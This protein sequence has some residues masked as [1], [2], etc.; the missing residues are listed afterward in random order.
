MLEDLF[1]P[2]WVCSSIL[3][4]QASAPK[5]GR[6]SHR[7]LDLF[8]CLETCFRWISRDST[9]LLLIGESVETVSLTISCSIFLAVYLGMQKV[10]VLA[11]YKTVKQALVN[12]A[13]EFEEREVTSIFYDFNKGHGILFSNG[14]VWKKIRCF[15]LSTL[16]DFG[17]GKRIT[18][19]KIIEEC[20]YLIEEFNNMKVKPLIIPIN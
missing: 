5:A 9:A 19:G 17:M 7:G 13:E 18:E 4:T 3:F 2:L 12:H 10:V 20:G 14:E 6:G 1:Q 8:P 11:G 15:A 16:K